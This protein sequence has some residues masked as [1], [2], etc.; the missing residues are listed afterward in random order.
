MLALCQEVGA[1][2][3]LAAASGAATFA[4]PEAAPAVELIAERV[5]DP[6]VA[7]QVRGWL[8][9]DMPYHALLRL[10]A[11][12]V[13]AL[14]ATCPPFEP[15]YGPKA[16]AE[17]E[18]MLALWPDVLVFP[19]STRLRPEDLI[20]LRAFPFHPLGLVADTVWADGAP[21]APSEYFF[22]DLDHARFK[23]REDLR[24]LGIQIP[25]AYQDGT[26]LVPGTDRH[27]TVLT[28]AARDRAGPRLWER[29]PARLALGRSLLGQIDALPDRAVARAA[30]LLMFEIV[31]EKSFPLEW[32]T[33]ATQLEG[34]A[35][36]AHLEKI[37]RK[38]AAGFFGDDTPGDTVIAALPAGRL[39]LRHMGPRAS[40]AEPV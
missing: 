23:V 16:G 17:L 14:D 4:L 5:S 35:G 1:R 20:C 30:R 37:C 27:R 3:R 33:L 22:H 21:A 26:T 2:A 11:R 19:T 10:C 38:Q 7:D 40:A 8:A 39:A 13:G 12:L 25:D 28:W 18:P 9:A 34:S 31:H 6:A 29:G 15:V 36:A 24:V 32:S